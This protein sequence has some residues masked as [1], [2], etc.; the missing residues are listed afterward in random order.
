MASDRTLGRIAWAVAAAT[1]SFA[2]V[3]VVLAVVEP[4]AA[5]RAGGVAMAVF[6]AFVY[7]SLTLL[8]ATVA[9]RQPRNSVGWLLL[10][11]ALALA[12]TLAA[13]HLSLSAL[14]EP[15][16][17]ERYAAWLAS[18]MWMVALV[19][20]FAIFPLV[21]P[22]GRPLTRRWRAVGWAAVLTGTVTWFGTAFAPG[23]ILSMAVTTKATN[24]FGIDIPGVELLGSIG[25]VLFAPTALAAIASVVV[26]FR[27]TTGTERQQLKWMVAA[28]ALL[29]VGWSGLGLGDAAGY[30]VQLGALLIVAGAVTVAMLRYRLYDIDVVINRT[31]VYGALTATLAAAYF[32]IVVL[33]QFALN[34]LTRESGLAVAGST[35]AVAA[36]FRPARARIQHLVDRRFYRTRYDATRTLTTFSAG[37]R[38]EVDLESLAGKL[39][40]VVGATMQPAHLSLWLR[41]R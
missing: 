24:P 30:A 32:G 2:G 34:P 20:A 23:P 21:F 26:R 1:T 4:A 36:L 28:A 37:L 3:G 38:D 15:G 33:L 5:D 11:I 9:S 12:I 31:L 17:V 29:P 25:F 35:L 10:L 6:E 14:D 13:T 8:G 19:P 22:T 39:R 40:G 18:W 7:T 16:Q 27:R 41:E